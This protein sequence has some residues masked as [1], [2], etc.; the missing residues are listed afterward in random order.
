[1]NTT[2]WKDGRR[3]GRM[4]EGRDDRKEG[5]SGGVREGRSG[6]VR[7]NLREL[8]KDCESSGVR[9]SLLCSSMFYIYWVCFPCY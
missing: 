5:R 1:M 9:L 8:G 3:E 4:E 7:E 6:G 2:N